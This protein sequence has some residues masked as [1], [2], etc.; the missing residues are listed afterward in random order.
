MQRSAGQTPR[1]TSLQAWVRALEYTQTLA[2]DPLVTLADI[3][4]DRA[5][6]DGT[7][8][9]LVDE[10]GE[11]TYRAL[12][13]QSNRYAR[14]A[15]AQGLGSGEIVA[16]LMPNCAEY[17]A[18]WLGITQVG[19]VVALLNTNLAPDAVARAI[20]TAGAGH[21]ILAAAML[22][23]AACVG[24]G[25]KCWVHGDGEFDRM[26]ARLPGS[27]LG[28]AARPPVG[29]DPA[30]LIYT[31][32][33]TGLPKAAKVSHARVLEWS[34]WFAGMM[35]AQPADRLYDCLP[36]YHSTGGVVAVGAMLV[37][38]GSVLIRQRFSAS[39]FWD[40]VA[41]WNCTII[42]YIGELCRYLVQSA[43]HPRERDHQLRLA[44]GNGLRRD[45]W[46]R[47]QERFALPQ[48]LEFYAATEGMVSLY[49]C[50][51]MPGAVGRIPAFL[52]HRRPVALIRCDAGTGDPLRD[53]AGLCIPCAP[54]EPGEA[55]GRITAAGGG[56][57]SIYT[58]ADASARKLLRDVAAMGDCWFR[59][60]DLM[61]KDAAGFYYFVD[62]LG[63]TFRWKG[64][65][66]ATAE[67]AAAISQCPGVIDAVVYGVAL[68]ATEGRAG[69]AAVTTDANFSLPA[70]RTHLMA[71]LPPYAR[72]LFVRL[73]RRIDLTGTFKLVKSALVREGYEAVAPGD[74]L[75]FDDH[76][77]GA[78]VP[79]DAPLLDAIAQGAVRL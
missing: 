57:L 16:L 29:R 50:E 45:V 49:N 44:C 2:G 46:E 27:R 19:C 24:E 70:L 52:A 79:C 13:E 23:S 71:T 38:G 12:A 42:Q 51:G 10:G 33:T 6:T 8:S 75:W 60:G 77:H 55:I 69:M 74:S 20:G 7:R 61:R 35:N 34:W 11:L 47:F 78:F 64:E 67:V 36:L 39:R 21:L 65:N 66:V 4:N 54:G 14:W 15:L 48:I 28:V 1:D 40:D 62:R 9:A 18:V 53:D 72:P 76:A 68:P 41:G 37:K 58:D 31:S 3:V 73:C 63:D 22:S 30:L 17:V 32:G 25:T 59:S 5:E 26:L 56:S 43:P